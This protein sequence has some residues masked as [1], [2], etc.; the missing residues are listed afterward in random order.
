DDIVEQYGPKSSRKTINISILPAS[1]DG[2]RYD[3][4][5]GDRHPTEEGLIIQRERQGRCV[6]VGTAVCIKS[7]RDDGDNKIFR[8]DEKYS[9]T[10]VE[11]SAGVTL[12]VFHRDGGMR[13][14]YRFDI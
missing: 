4:S 12:S 10:A 6:E 8:K 5:E 9:Y 3:Y 11:V 13:R 14:P 1:D 7:W 2:P